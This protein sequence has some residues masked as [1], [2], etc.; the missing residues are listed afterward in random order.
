M[1]RQHR[2]FRCLRPGHE[3]PRLQVVL[4]GVL[5][6]LMVDR[7]VV[8][9]QEIWVDLCRDGGRQGGGCCST[10]PRSHQHQV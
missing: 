1:L 5:V 9:L 7:V 10:R 6:G 2:S 8:V 3:R 4:L